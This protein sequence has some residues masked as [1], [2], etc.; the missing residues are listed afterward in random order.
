LKRAYRAALLLTA[1]PRGA[2]F[3]VARAIETDSSALRRQ[4]LIAALAWAGPAELGACEAPE[5]RRVMALPRVQRHCY[6]LRLLERLP[7][8][9][10]A[11]LLELSPAGIDA[12]AAQAAAALIHLECF[13]CL[14][15]G[16]SASVAQTSVI[17]RQRPA[18]FSKNA[19]CAA[20]L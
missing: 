10:C 16:G 4:T 17:Q 5:L 15:S 13:G 2:E 8:T 3:A 18:R 14:R 11:R 9:H 6:V 1:S 7:A 20:G 12:A 19:R